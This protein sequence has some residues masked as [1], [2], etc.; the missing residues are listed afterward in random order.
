MQASDCFIVS[1][2]VEVP[3]HLYTEIYISLLE[4]IFLLFLLYILVK[5]LYWFASVTYTGRRYVSS[6]QNI[7]QDNKCV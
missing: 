2:S 6:F 7:S 4:I 3:K 5:L 1:S